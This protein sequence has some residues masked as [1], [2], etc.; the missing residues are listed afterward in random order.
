MEPI[1]RGPPSFRFIY[2][3][4][5][6]RGRLV[7]PRGQLVKELENYSYTLPPYVRFQSFRSR[8]MNLGYIKSEMLWYLKGDRYDTS[9]GEKAKMWRGLVNDDGSI[10]S[11]YGQYIFSGPRQFDN[12]VRVLSEDRDTRRASMMILGSDHL[13]SDTDDVPCTYALGFRVRGDSL[14]MSVH[15]RSQDAIFGMTNDAPAFSLI[16]E[17]VLNA[18][19]SRY[20]DLQLGDYFHVADSFHAYER[21]FGM[22]ESLASGDD[23]Y[24]PVA[25]PRISGPAEVDFL[26]A[27]DFTSIPGQY[28]FTRWL[29]DG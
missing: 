25:C 16:Q 4:L 21:H 18:L 13:L 7:S 19:L 3:D 14:N 10:N 24:D 17:M 29:T 20:P 12:V 2:R 22:L 26:R 1:N 27:L 5:Q 28:G 9:I 15:M 8:K 23:A 6:Q 11:N